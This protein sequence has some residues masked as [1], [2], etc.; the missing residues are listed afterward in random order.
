LA[1]RAARIR[2]A[3]GRFS[4]REFCDRG[5]RRSFDEGRE[6]QRNKDSNDLR[7]ETA[8]LR[9]GDVITA[10]GER[11]RRPA[12]EVHAGLT[13]V[14]VGCLGC[15]SCAQAP[16]WRGRRRRYLRTRRQEKKKN[17][18]TK[19]KKKKKKKKQKKNKKKT[20]KKNKKQKNKN[21]GGLKE[22]PDY[23]LEKRMLAVGWARS[24]RRGQLSPNRPGRHQDD[25]PTS[26][27]AR[28]PRPTAAAR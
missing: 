16:Q 1:G 19:K 4:P 23:L 10:G 8:P 2:R 14:R 9:H 22:H 5:T 21:G 15:R 6:H 25:V 17:K 28:R 18:K 13:R 11:S 26:A 24:F 27:A 12:D 7:V 3:E 20:K